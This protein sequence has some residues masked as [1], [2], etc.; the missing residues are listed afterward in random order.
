M[1]KVSLKS[2]HQHCRKSGKEWL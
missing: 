1:I 2:L